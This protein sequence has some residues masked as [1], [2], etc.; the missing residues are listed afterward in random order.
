[1]DIGMNRHFGAKRGVW[2]PMSIGASGH[3][4]Q[5]GTR[6]KWGPGKISTRTNG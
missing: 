1:M 3:L 2:G 5:I 6:G 4:V